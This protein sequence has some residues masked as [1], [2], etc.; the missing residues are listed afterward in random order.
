MGLYLLQVLSSRVLMDFRNSTSNC[1]HLSEK[2]SLEAPTNNR[3]CHD[4]NDVAD[5]KGDAFVYPL[6]ISNCMK[7]MKGVQKFLF[8][9]L[10]QKNRED[11][12]K[13]ELRKNLTYLYIYFIYLF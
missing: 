8:L 7:N 1:A 5:L 9:T 2:F 6:W 4:N 10:F 12:L 13:L 3:C 11:L